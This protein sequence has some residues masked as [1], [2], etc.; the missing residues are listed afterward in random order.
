MTLQVIGNIQ[1]KM[2]VGVTWTPAG[3]WKPAM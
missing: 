1:A 3:P 2:K